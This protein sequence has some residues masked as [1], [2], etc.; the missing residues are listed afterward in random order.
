MPATPAQ[1]RAANKYIKEKTDELKIRIPK[2]KKVKYQAHAESKGESLNG[3]M[4]RAADEAIERDKAL[5]AFTVQPTDKED[6][7]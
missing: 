5:A 6:A 2:G 4:S 7:E 3:F 1:R